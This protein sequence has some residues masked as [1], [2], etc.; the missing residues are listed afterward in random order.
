MNG[1]IRITRPSIT[2]GDAKSVLERVQGA[3]ARRFLSA[4]RSIRTKEHLARAKVLF[5]ERRPAHLHGSMA[6]GITISRGSCSR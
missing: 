6:T 4:G 5:D 2:R 3:P 1:V